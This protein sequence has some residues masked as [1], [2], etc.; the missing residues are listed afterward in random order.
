MTILIIFCMLILI[1]VGTVAFHIFSIAC[2]WDLE[3]ARD[4]IVDYA[5]GIIAL[6]FFGFILLTVLIFMSLSIN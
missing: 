5:A 6:A 4:I 1:M 2:N 3:R